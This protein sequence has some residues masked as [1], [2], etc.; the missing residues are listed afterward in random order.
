MTF[1]LVRNDIE[2]RENMI[3]MLYW[4]TK[5][6][7]VLFLQ[8]TG[9]NYITRVRCEDFFLAGYGYQL[10]NSTYTIPARGQK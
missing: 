4:H 10:E 2:I 7:I 6:I 8:I 3:D 9:D 5:S 1:L